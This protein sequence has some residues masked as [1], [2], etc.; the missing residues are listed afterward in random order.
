MAAGPPDPADRGAA[1]RLSVVILNWNA[2][3]AARDRALEVSAW[4]ELRPEVWVVENGSRG[5]DLARLRAALPDAHVLDA[6]RNLGFG[7]GV[8]LAL[9]EISTP[10]ALLLNHDAGLDEPAARHLVALLETRREIAVAGPALTD[11]AGRIEALGGRDI[12]RH[13]RTHRR[14]DDVDEPPPAEAI[15]V[16]YVPG[17]VALLRTEAVRAV[18]ALDERFFFSGEMPDLCRRLVDRGW[19]CVVLPTARGW[20]DRGGRGARREA[21]DAYYSLRNRFLFLRKHP[22]PGRR[23]LWALYAVAS[24]LRHLARGRPRRAR[25]ELLALSHGLRGRFGDAHRELGW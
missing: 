9:G 11:P 1:A 24:S 5:D 18:G 4:S 14:P 12:G 19:R 10:F 22:S 8:N 13:V 17:T 2:W 25:A 6:G 16:A 7:G 15:D 21:L 3:E 23:W 20:H